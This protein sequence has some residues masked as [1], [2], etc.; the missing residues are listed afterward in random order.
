MQ[1]KIERKFWVNKWSDIIILFILGTLVFVGISNLGISHWLYEI[2][3]KTVSILFLYYAY[4]ALMKK[5]R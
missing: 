2:G 3:V 5:V 1:K 4:M